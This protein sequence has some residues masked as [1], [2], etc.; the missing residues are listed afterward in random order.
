MLILFIGEIIF[1]IRSRRRQQRENV[2]P[3]LGREKR[4]GIYPLVRAFTTIFLRDLT[5]HTLVGDILAGTFD[6]EYATYF[7][8]N[9]VAH[10]SGVEDP[11]AFR[12]LRQLDQQFARLERATTHAERKA[13]LAILSDHGQS[14]G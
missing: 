1:E 12:T 4:G 9:A 8:Y 11:D 13:H 7:G 2:I 5:T 14:Q 10:H 6:A 3:R